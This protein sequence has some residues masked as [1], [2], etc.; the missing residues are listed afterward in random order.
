MWK[1]LKLLIKELKIE[2]QIVVRK[3][4]EITGDSVIYTNAEGGEAKETEETGTTH[5]N[6]DNLGINVSPEKTKRTKHPF[7]T[8][9]I[10]LIVMG[11]IIVGL[12]M[13]G[14]N[15]KKKKDSYLKYFDN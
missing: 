11:I 14:R 2:A 4:V 10:S 3:I 5:I 1:I 7:R 6:T 13:I 12:A 9:L 15:E 8:V